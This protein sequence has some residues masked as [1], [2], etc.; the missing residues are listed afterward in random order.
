MYVC[1]MHYVLYAIYNEQ[2][3]YSCALFEAH[4]LLRSLPPQAM[5]DSRGRQGL[6]LPLPCKGAPSGNLECAAAA[7]NQSNSLAARRVKLQVLATPST[8]AGRISGT[9]PRRKLGM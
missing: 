4:F 2:Q 3:I 5:G 6:E 9:D 7:L 8:A 1:T